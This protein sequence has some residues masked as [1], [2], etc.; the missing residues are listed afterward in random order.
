SVNFALERWLDVAWASKHCECVRDSVTIDLMRWFGDVHRDRLRRQQREQRDAR[1]PPR[2]HAAAHAA[3]APPGLA[4]GAPKRKPSVGA[5][6]SA[7]RAHV[8]E[9]RFASLH[10]PVGTCGGCLRAAAGR[11]VECEQCGLTV[12][13]ACTGA[14]AGAGA[15]KC[16][17]CVMDTDQLGCEL[18][19][20]LNGVLLP[21]RRAAGLRGKPAFAHFL[22]ANFVP[23]AFL[24][25]PGPAT[26]DVE[27][28]K[29]RPAEPAPSAVATRSRTAG[30]P[31]AGGPMGHW[32]WVC[33]TQK[34]LAEAAGTCAICGGDAAS[35]V[36][37]ACAEPM[38]GR[39]VHPMCAATHGMSPM[40]L[41]WSTRKV[42]CPDHG[43]S[44]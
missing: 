5:A 4:A 40:L 17:N 36:P 8:A 21:V 13:G 9:R 24:D 16:G 25:F 37:V 41:D 26:R 29:T 30:R 12:H 1:T 11:A 7:K 31:P 38:C 2:R 20:F 42:Y 44:I 22:C 23:Q 18:C 33:G 35:G 19:G 39:S 27:R 43:R 15:Y 3:V 6:G 32:A 10:T 28:A 34:A 14:G